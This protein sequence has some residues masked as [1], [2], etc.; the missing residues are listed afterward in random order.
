MLLILLLFSFLLKVE[1]I[2]SLDNLS[3]IICVLVVISYW[4]LILFPFFWSVIRY[5]SIV[6]FLWLLGCLSLR[7]DSYVIINEE[8]AEG[9]EVMH[10]NHD[11]LPVSIYLLQ[12]SLII[13]KNS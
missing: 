10:K 1:A 5:V 2:G 3:E 11:Y 6:I 7:V 9:F 4:N 12:F 8:K 13:G